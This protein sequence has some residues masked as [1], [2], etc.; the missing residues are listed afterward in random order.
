MEAKIKLE[1]GRRLRF[2][3]SVVSAIVGKHAD[4]EGPS[5]RFCSRHD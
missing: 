4:Q 5:V 3:R 1:D 2:G